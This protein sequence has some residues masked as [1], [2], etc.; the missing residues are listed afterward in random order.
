MKTMVL[1]MHF[2]RFRA[3]LSTLFPFVVGL[4]WSESSTLSALTYLGW[5]ALL[6]LF[7]CQLNNLADYDTDKLNGSRQRDP[8]LSGEL[9]RTRAAGWVLMDGIILSTTIP[10]VFSGIGARTGA[11]VL[12]LLVSYGNIYQKKSRLSPIFIDYLYGLCM[13]LPAALVRF[14]QANWVIG[15]RFLLIGALGLTFTVLNMYA[16]NLK[17]LEWDRLAGS[18]TTAITCGVVVDAGTKTGFRFSVKYNLVLLVPQSILTGLLFASW[19]F[20]HDLSPSAQLVNLTGL[21]AAIMACICM[22]DDLCV[23]PSWFT[24]LKRPSRRDQKVRAVRPMHAFLN[25]AAV[26]LIAAGF[27]PDP[28]LAVLLLFSLVAITYMLIAY[29]NRIAMVMR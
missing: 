17:D 2:G 12:I 6:H 28:L 5:G 18:R 22:A 10:V 11:A 25:L 9:S 26:I 7:I 27:S 20:E 23:L 8:L 24:Y 29:G 3:V 19:Y 15:G 21:T 13:A 14:S 4:L 1:Y 16:G